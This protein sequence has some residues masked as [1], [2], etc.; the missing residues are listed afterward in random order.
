MTIKVKYIYNTQAI[1]VRGTRDWR[2]AFRNKMKFDY[3]NARLNGMKMVEP[4]EEQ[5]EGSKGNY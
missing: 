4:S 1:E 3:E 2:T 5:I